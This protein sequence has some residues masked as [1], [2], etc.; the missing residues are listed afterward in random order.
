MSGRFLVSVL[1]TLGVVAVLLLSVVWVVDYLN[2]G[3]PIEENTIPLTDVQE[4][5]LS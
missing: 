2:I 4:S 5:S 1:V 3:P